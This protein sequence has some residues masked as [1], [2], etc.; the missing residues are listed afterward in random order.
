[1][2][3]QTDFDNDLDVGCDRRKRIKDDADAFSVSYWNNEAAICC[4]LQMGQ[5]G[6]KQRFGLECSKYEMPIRHL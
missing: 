2:S 1:M 5:S 4:H 6:K 3:E